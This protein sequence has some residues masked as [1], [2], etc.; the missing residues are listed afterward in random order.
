MFDT[1][2]TCDLKD[3][4]ASFNM[5]ERTIRSVYLKKRDSCPQSKAFP[6]VQPNLSPCSKKLKSDGQ[7]SEGETACESQIS[8]SKICKEIETTM[9]KCVETMGTGTWLASQSQ[10]G[11]RRSRI[12]TFIID[13]NGE[14]RRLRRKPEELTAEK[15]HNCPY[16]DCQKSYTSKCSLFLHIKRNHHTFENLKEG[17]ELPVSQ[18][19]RVKNTINM[20]KV[21]KRS[22]DCDLKLDN[23]GLFGLL[24]MPVDEAGSSYEM[25]PQ[26]QTK[27]RQLFS[28]IKFDYMEKTSG[29]EKSSGSDRKL[30][31]SQVTA[32]QSM[33][34]DKARLNFVSR[35]DSPDFQSR[36]RLQV[37]FGVENEIFSCE[38]SKM[39]PID[40]VQFESQK[41]LEDEFVVSE[42]EEVEDY[43]S[44]GVSFD[45]QKLGSIS[46]DHE[47]KLKR[48]FS[49]FDSSKSY[50]QEIDEIN[51]FDG[52][53]NFQLDFNESDLIPGHADFIDFCKSSLK[54]EEETHYDFELDFNMGTPA[55]GLEC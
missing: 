13:Q 15:T 48:R 40:I 17:S 32:F 3:S 26:K 12:A 21:L 30:S 19:N 4:D 42:N 9:R 25:T 7:W 18:N 22:E 37:P 31:E 14:K 28:E 39:R 53:S 20:W 38:F 47:M 24:G 50:S 54:C 16:M 27:K 49:D 33:G 23:D 51:G 8:A 29:G 10:N 6:Q 45:E 5:L 1:A 44:M 46:D 2:F 52:V 43:E 36:D 35:P 34:I 55:H 41:K 11:K